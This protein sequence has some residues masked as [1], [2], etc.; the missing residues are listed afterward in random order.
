[1]RSRSVALLTAVIFL[2]VSSA[3]S[4]TPRKPSSPNPGE[5]ISS[6]EGSRPASSSYQ[7]EPWWKRDENQ[8]LVA[9]LIVLG[10]GIAIGATIYIASGANG[11]TLQI[12]K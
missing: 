12:R 11:L 5:E 9:F 3:C 1:M 8:W 2:I 6:S 4:H 10:I 7:E